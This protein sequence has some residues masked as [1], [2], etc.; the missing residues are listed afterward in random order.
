[1]TDIDLSA[2]HKALKDAAFYGVEDEIV[3]SAL[4]YMKENPTISIP[5]A[6][7]MG[8]DEWVK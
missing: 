8:Y 6:M 1:M 5:D 4:E 7:Q 2:I 3:A